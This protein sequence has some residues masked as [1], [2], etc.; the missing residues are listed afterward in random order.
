MTSPERRFA[1]AR[2]ACEHGVASDID[3][4]LQARPELVSASGADGQTLLGVACDAYTGHRALPPVHGSAVHLDV[5]ERLLRAG[6]DP[7]ACDTNGWAPLHTAAMTGNMDLAAELLEAGAARSGSLMGAQGGSPLA[8]ALF[9]AK[10]AMGE[11]LATPATPDNL[12]TA[13]ALGRDMNRFFDEGAPTPKALSGLDFYRPS[14]QWPDWERR[15]DAQE[16]LD[17]ALSWAAR[18]GQLESMEHLV[19]RGAN[20]NAN[21]YRGTPLLWAIYSD[22]EEVAGWLMDQGAD[23]DLK[24]DFGGTTHGTGAVAMHLAAQYSGLKCLRLLIDRGADASI[25]DTAYSST[26]LEWAKYA[27]ATESV[28]MLSES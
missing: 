13:A 16:L 28:E 21:P 14:D 8:L 18:N 19:Q 22:R 5:I 17:E 20:V 9:Y 3:R 25:R 15:L 11:L 2:Q 26:P 12:R 27:E 24:H 7:S 10:P 1:E 23:P 4:H 6:A